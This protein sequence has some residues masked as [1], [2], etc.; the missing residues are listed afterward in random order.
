MNSSSNSVLFILKSNLCSL[1]S[2]SEAEVQEAL[3]NSMAG[4]TVLV[5]AH[6]LSTVQRADRIMVLDKGSIVEQGT[7]DELMRK[8]RPQGA[9]H[10]TY[11]QLVE[12]Q[13]LLT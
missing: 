11:R 2:Q 1:D 13:A 5:I 3:D 10:T 9:T 12:R 8:E 4:R 6:R 7:H